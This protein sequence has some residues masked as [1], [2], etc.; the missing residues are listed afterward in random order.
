MPLIVELS[1]RKESLPMTDEHSNGAQA[2][3]EQAESAGQS[4][5]SHPPFP[6]DE[7]IVRML[8][9][10]ND[11]L[12]TIATDERVEHHRNAQ[13]LFYSCK[14]WFA[15]HQ[16]GLKKDVRAN[17]YYLDASGS[18][19][20]RGPQTEDQQQGMPFRSDDAKRRSEIFVSERNTQGG[21]GSHD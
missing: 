9:V 7:Q 20:S 14:E 2:A 13:N 4:K 19:S 10:M 6:K 5:P 18:A 21:S 8:I 17:M 3:G 15:L 16:I 1:A 12:Y 11:A